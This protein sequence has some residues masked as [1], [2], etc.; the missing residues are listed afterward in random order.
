MQ[1]DKN[2][3]IVDF[4][5]AG[6]TILA[7]ILALVYQFMLHELPCPLCLLQRVGMLGIAFGAVMNLKYGKAFRHDLVMIMASLFSLVVALR[8]VLLHILP[9]DPGYGSTLFGLHFYTWNDLI[10]FAFI[11]FISISPLFKG[12]NISRILSRFYLSN[13]KVANLFFILLFA[14]SLVNLVAVYLECGFLPCPDNPTSY[15]Y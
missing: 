8:Q 4:S 3:S 1:E 9:G 12:I 5:I 13:V 11:I 2:T 14:L 15:L 7:N 10:S 6:I